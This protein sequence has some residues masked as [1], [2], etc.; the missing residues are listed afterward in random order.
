M[1]VCVCVKETVVVRS[2]YFDIWLLKKLK[3][4]TKKEKIKQIKESK[5]LKSVDFIESF[6]NEK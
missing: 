2:F 6:S 3:Y 5:E 4:Q 1:C